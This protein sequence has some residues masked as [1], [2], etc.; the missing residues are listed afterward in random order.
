[1]HRT[2]DACLC[3]LV[4]ENHQVNLIV[5]SHAKMLIYVTLSPKDDPNGTIFMS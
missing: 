2:Q 4:K 5:R 1:M 3:N